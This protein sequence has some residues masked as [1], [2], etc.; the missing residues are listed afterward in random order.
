MEMD[1]I[2]HSANHN[3]LVVTICS[4]PIQFRDLI[5]NYADPKVVE[6]LYY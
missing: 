5:Q 2:S 4:S 1:M 6:T 3:K